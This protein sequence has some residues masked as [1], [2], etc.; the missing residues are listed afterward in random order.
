MP[1]HLC[2][3]NSWIEFLME[4]YDDRSHIRPRQNDN[5]I[6]FNSSAH[7]GALLRDNVSFNFDNFHS[8][9]ITG[10][11]SHDFIIHGA[12]IKRSLLTVCNTYTR[13]YNQLSSK[14]NNEDRLTDYYTRVL[15][16][17][18]SIRFNPARNNARMFRREWKISHTMIL[19][20]EVKRK[21]RGP[22]LYNSCTRNGITRID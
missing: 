21:A 4:L 16:N 14:W 12:K 15:W 9:Y 20:Y 7:I 8:G 10:R 22:C 11:V 6:R 3:P 5:E 19:K 18:K 2:A 1:C 13:H 17:D